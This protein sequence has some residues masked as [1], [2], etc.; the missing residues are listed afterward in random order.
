[1]DGTGKAASSEDNDETILTKALN[2]NP[3]KLNG[4]LTNGTAAAAVGKTKGDSG[5]S[6]KA[7]ELLNQ[8]E[9][10]NPDGSTELKIPVPWGFIAGN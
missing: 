7:N 4:P 1:M 10:M 2:L 5:S 8:S 9:T 6:P 3:V